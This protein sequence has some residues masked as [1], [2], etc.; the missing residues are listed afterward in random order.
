SAKRRWGRPAANRLLGP[1]TTFNRV[2]TRAGVGS[3][4]GHRCGCERPRPLEPVR[5]ELPSRN[6]AILSNAGA[7]PATRLPRHKAPSR[8][9]RSPPARLDADWAVLLMRR[10]CRFDDYRFEAVFAAIGCSHE[11]K[12]APDD[13]C[14]VLSMPNRK[15]DTA[16][17]ATVANLEAKLWAAA[18][19]Q[20]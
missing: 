18:D 2:R 13:S 15:N 12:V 1:P 3:E 17:T 14:R 4:F 19:A 7:D 9:V 20:N 8:A 6:V 10:V 5:H 11:R 16:K